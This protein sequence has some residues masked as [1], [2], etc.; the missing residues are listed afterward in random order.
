[1]LLSNSDIVRIRGLGFSEDF[2]IINK[3]GTASSRICRENASFMTD[4]DAPSTLIDLK[5]VGCTRPFS[6][7]TREKQT[8]I[9][10]ARIT[11]SFN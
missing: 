2:F 5:V 1:M 4:S 3:T 8:S 7:K 10:T 11:G 6:M 9:H